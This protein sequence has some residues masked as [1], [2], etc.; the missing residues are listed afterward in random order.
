MQISSQGRPQKRRTFLH[1]SIGSMALPWI[2]L[3]S[4]TNSD[5]PQQLTLTTSLKIIRWCCTLNLPITG[6]RLEWC[7]ALP[8]SL[9]KR[10]SWSPTNGLRAVS[11]VRMRWPRRRKPKCSFHW[12]HHLLMSSSKGDYRIRLWTASSTIPPIDT[13]LILSTRQKVW[14]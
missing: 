1:C 13:W 9:K 4:R 7:I 8:R 2:S 14:R 3:C 10:K 5:H 12:N 11:M 6:T